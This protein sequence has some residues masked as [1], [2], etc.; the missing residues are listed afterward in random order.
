MYI[1]TEKKK[2]LIRITDYQKQYLD[3]IKEHPKES[4][5]DALNH[6]ISTDIRNIR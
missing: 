1:M 2:Q 5:V 4:Y 3:D 6:L